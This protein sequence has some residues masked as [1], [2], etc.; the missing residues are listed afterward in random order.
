MEYGKIV[1]QSDSEIEFEKITKKEYECLLKSS[2]EA[3]GA[4]AI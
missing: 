4:K 1:A 2:S 3:D